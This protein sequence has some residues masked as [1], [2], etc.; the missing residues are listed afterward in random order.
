MEP[1]QTGLI[2]FLNS[3]TGILVSIGT[4]AGL[5]ISAFL[6]G[7]RLA[8]RRALKDEKR[9][10]MKKRLEKIYAPL[11]AV[12]IDVH[13]TTVSS[14]LRPYFRWRLRDFLKNPKGLPFRYRLR[15]LFDRGVRKSISVEFGYFP[16]TELR[17]IAST[18]VDV[19][20]SKLLN[21][22]QRIERARQESPPDPTSDE[23]TEDELALIDHI[24]E[25]YSKLSKKLGG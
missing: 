4:I 7:W 1:K 23:I 10:L 5:I 3:F 2:E 22:I 16:L 24:W 6:T 19:A 13:I 20:D 11:R 18:N 8:K 15:H 12:L 21:L 9:A 25:Q 14:A 17:R